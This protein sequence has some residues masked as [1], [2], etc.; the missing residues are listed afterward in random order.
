MEGFSDETFMT[1]TFMITFSGRNVPGDLHDALSIDYEKSSINTLGSGFSSLTESAIFE[2]ITQLSGEDF[3]GQANITYDASTPANLPA[4]GRDRVPF[5]NILLNVTVDA[6]TIE[7]ALINEGLEDIQVTT[8]FTSPFD[9]ARADFLDWLITFV[10]SSGDST[11]VGYRAPFTCS[12][13]SNLSCS[14]KSIQGGSFLSGNFTLVTEFNGLV[15]RS[16]PI[17]A[18]SSG[19]T[20]QNTF[21]ELFKLD[22]PGQLLETTVKRKI[23]RPTTRAKW[24]G[25]YEW[26]FTFP[27][28]RGSSFD[29]RFTFENNLSGGASLR[30]GSNNA[31]PFILHQTQSSLPGEI[32]EVQVINFLGNSSGD[33][34][35]GPFLLRLGSQRTKSSL[36][37]STS[38]LHDLEEALLELDRVKNVSLSTLPDSPSSLL[39]RLDSDV[40]VEIT[41]ANS[42]GDLPPLE[43]ESSFRNVQDTITVSINSQYGISGFRAKKGTRRAL[44]CGGRG[45]CVMDTFNVVFCECDE[46]SA[47]NVMFANGDNVGTAGN[48]QEW[49]GG[50]AGLVEAC[51]FR[52]NRG[53]LNRCPTNDE[54]MVCSGHGKCSSEFGL[55][56]NRY[57][58]I[59][60]RD[61]QG[62]DCSQLGCPSHPALFDKAT[63]RNFAHVPAECG[64]VGSCQ[65][66][67][68]SCTC[69]LGL[70]AQSDEGTDCRRLR[71]PGTDG[72]CLNGGK[73]VFMHELARTSLGDKGEPIKGAYRTAWDANFL[74]G[75]GCPRPFVYSGR[76]NQAFVRRIGFR[77]QE[78]TVSMLFLIW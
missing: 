15:A 52:N 13:S 38:T 59:C 44:V 73:C 60:D 61:Y 20:V 37:L 53:T 65:T 48:R 41:F 33:C 32:H 3:I 6:Q 12:P 64:N 34:P 25:Q 49:R 29:F 26:T 43:A 8:R 27:H 18:S 14:V 2:S 69:R 36:S 77:C 9:T 67:S 1:D 74:R 10:P 51:N 39:C 42:V 16:K 45:G 75:C 28:V 4:F 62:H 57:I 46:D 17:D 63:S 40:S 56:D 24:S 58:C 55:E 31:F 47:G 22:E 76:Y 35:A 21:A 78:A 68:G 66:A 5:I 50:G 30:A 71:C 54:T 23:R 11:S 70:I 72:T 19:Q 7:E